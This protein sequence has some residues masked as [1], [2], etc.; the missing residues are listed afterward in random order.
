MDSAVELQLREL[1]FQRLAEIVADQGV[2]T[3]TEL[4]SLRV[5]NET[6][7]IIDRS[8]GIWNP[9]EMLATLSVISNP[10]GPYADAHVG[11]SLFAYDYRA[12]S[13]DGDN[14]KMRRAFELRLPIILLRTIRPGVFVPVFPVYVV[15]DDTANR[16][17]MLA[18]DE[19]L[20]FVADPLHLNP[21]ERA[22]AE[23]AV[24]QR[25]HQP[26]FRGRVML[27]YNQSCTVCTLKHGKLL[28]AAHII[29]DDK[30]HGIPIVENGLSMCKIHHAAYDANLLGISPYFSVRINSDLMAEIDGP[31]LR[32]GLQEM[33]GRQLTLP[34]RR[35]DRPSQD[36][37]A[38]RF[39]EFLTAS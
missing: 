36:R 17:F 32:H 9:K 29:G 18:L 13:T 31:M 6:R 28:D 35:I 22:Y 38:E 26:E 14:R 37:L 7:R 2:I 15:A 23:R 30:P 12:G 3:R 16:Q 5:G 8:R 24:K 21:I 4:E 11:E 1:I 39:A 19:S 25:L 20:Q 10:E 33:D 34:K 27:A